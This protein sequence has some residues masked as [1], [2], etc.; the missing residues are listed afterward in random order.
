MTAKAERIKSELTGL[1]S[2]DRAELARFLIESLD[3]R[4]EEGVA[5]AWDA[6]LRRRAEEIESGRVTGE[7]A[8][9]VLRELRAKYS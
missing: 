9:Q 5:A 2:E 8:E 7:R 6:E 3:E 4:E 1:T